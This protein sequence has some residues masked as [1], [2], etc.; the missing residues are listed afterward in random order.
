MPVFT[1]RIRQAGE[2]A[3]FV[4]L[5]LLFVWGIWLAAVGALQGDAARILSGVAL[6]ACV[7]ASTAATP[8][9]LMAVFNRA[10]IH[11][12]L[13]VSERAGALHETLVV[14]DLHA[15]T[16]MW[17][18]DFLKKNGLG[19]VDLPRMIEGNLAIEV[20]TATTKA[21]VGMNFVS[22]PDTLNMLTSL[23]VLQ[24][25][26]RTTWTSLRDRAL[27]MAQRLDQFAAASGG[28]FQV[29]RTRGE[30][31]RY[32]AQRPTGPC[33]A[34]GV[35]G[36]QGA[37]CFEG[38]LEE[39]DAMFAAGFRLA[40]L[41]HFFDNNVGGSAHGVQKGG[42]TD[43]G[44]AVIHRMESLGMVVDLAHASP[45][46]IDEVLDM[47][48]RPPIISHTG[49]K[50]ILDTS[51]TISDAH[52]RAVADKEGL[53]GIGFW[54]DAVGP[55]GVAA[56]VRA[57]RYVSDLVG[58]ER[59]TLGSDYDGMINAPFD[60]AALPLL[61]EAILES[62]LPEQAIRNVMGGNVVRF[63]TRALPQA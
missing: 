1:E 50:G 26:P 13:T 51:R 20:F 46:V 58:D 15:D 62:G 10:Q 63:L 9:I 28:A 7:A 19:H 52:I 59:V 57:I 61:T 30:L 55:G 31:E 18:R 11:G 43:F 3:A 44:R 45:R 17:R 29:I 21:P 53:I 24:G 35:L 4:V 33:R 54:R 47:A 25:W 22:T 37:H 5:F 42:L 56:I 40:G 48:T 34:A 14:A 16:M 23:A 49:P 36:I 12:P 27:Y 41:T 38:R 32:L 60:A 39:V 8:Y 6:L 2:W